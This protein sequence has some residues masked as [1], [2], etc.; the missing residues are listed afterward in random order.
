MRKE[1]EGEVFIIDEKD[2]ELF[3]KAKEQS[4]DIYFLIENLEFYRVDFVIESDMKKGDLKKMIDIMDEIDNDKE[5]TDKKKYKM[6]LKLVDKVR[7]D[8]EVSYLVDLLN[9]YK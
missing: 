7:T 1:Y 8:D 4:D 3:D 6:L 5:L 9:T 2:S